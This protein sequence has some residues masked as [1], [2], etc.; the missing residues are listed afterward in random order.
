MPS[1]QVNINLLPNSASTQNPPENSHLQ[2]LLLTTTLEGAPAQSRGITRSYQTLHHHQPFSPSVGS[3]EVTG[4]L[5]VFPLPRPN[6]TLNPWAARDHVHNIGDYLALLPST[7]TIPP[8][9][10]LSLYNPSVKQ[11]LEYLDFQ[12]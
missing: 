10:F 2:I 12:I 4:V 1:S 3:A 11:I 6:F 9:G 7:D 5:K 8:P